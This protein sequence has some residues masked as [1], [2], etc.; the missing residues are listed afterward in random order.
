MSVTA[1]T[2]TLA[3]AA[4]TA[5]VILGSDAPGWL[6]NRGLAARLVTLDGDVC[7]V[8]GWPAADGHGVER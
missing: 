1:S 3:N 4:S 6:A 7:V 8:G 5:A 2:C